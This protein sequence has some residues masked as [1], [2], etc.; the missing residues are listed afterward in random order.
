MIGVEFLYN[1]DAIPDKSSVVC[2]CLADF[3]PISLTIVSA[4]FCA[5]WGCNQ[6][7]AYRLG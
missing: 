2:E 1:L 5:Q 4:A 3:R 6:T 7:S